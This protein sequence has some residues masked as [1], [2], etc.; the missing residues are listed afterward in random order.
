MRSILEIS[1][2]IYKLPIH[3]RK[4]TVGAHSEERGSGQWFIK[5]THP[6]GIYNLVAEN[7]SPFLWVNINQIMAISFGSIYCYYY[8]VVCTVTE[9]SGS[10]EE[11]IAWKRWVAAKEGVLD[12]SELRLGQCARIRQEKKWRRETPI[13]QTRR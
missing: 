10:I 3:S 7:D 13:F 4:Q 6:K 8:N 12:M 2:I 11:K 5:K 1:V 9:I